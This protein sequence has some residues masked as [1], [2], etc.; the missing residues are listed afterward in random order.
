MQVALGAQEVQPA[1]VHDADAVGDLLG[2]GQGMGRHEYGVS[3][4]AATVAGGL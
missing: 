2:N 3:P 4:A 1:M